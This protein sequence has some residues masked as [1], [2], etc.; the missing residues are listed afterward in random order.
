MTI[1]VTFSPVQCLRQEHDGI[2]PVCQRSSFQVYCTNRIHKTFCSLIVLQMLLQSHAKAKVAVAI[3]HCKKK[4]KN[5]KTQQPLTKRNTHLLDSRDACN[6]FACWWASNTNTSQATN[7]GTQWIGRHLDNKFV[8]ISQ[9]L[10]K[11]SRET[12]SLPVLNIAM[13]TGALYKGVCAHSRKKPGA[14]V[15]STSFFSSFFS[16]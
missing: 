14:A 5:K 8:R 7:N 11:S 13:A 12:E 1:S 4:I 10:G 3:S 15:F 9:T 2:K 16:H 6:A